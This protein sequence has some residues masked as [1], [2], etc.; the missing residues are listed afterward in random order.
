[1]LPFSVELR[2]GLPVAEQIMFAVRK[3]VV[4]R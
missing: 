2:P 4:T 1:V 3:A